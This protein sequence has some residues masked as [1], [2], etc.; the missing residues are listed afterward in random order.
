MSTCDL[1]VYQTNKNF[2]KNVRDTTRGLLKCNFS[3]IIQSS[4]QSISDDRNLNSHNF[5]E[6]N[7]MADRMND[8]EHIPDLLEYL[9]PYF[10]QEN[11]V[12][13]VY[14]FLGYPKN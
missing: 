6:E 14:N 7:M 3:R 1:P 5:L 2:K 9:P 11:N 4:N 13:L 12:C 10:L 8:L